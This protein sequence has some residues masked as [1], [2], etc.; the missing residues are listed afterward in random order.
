[1]YKGRVLSFIFL[2][3]TL[4]VKAQDTLIVK[5]HEADSIF[6]TNNYYLL[7][8]LMNVEAQKAQI[9]QAKVY[10][11][12]VFTADLNVYDPENKKAFH[13]GQ[14]GQKSFQLEQLILLGG[15]RKSEIDMAKTN[16]KIAELEFQKLL[17]QLKFRLH[18]DLFSVGQQQFLL[19]KYDNQL[20]LLN[21]L[22]SAYQ[23]QADKGNIPLK[24]V[25]RLKG[26]YLKLNNDRAEL[27]KQYY[28]T[29]ANLQTLLQ[30][31]SLVVFQFSEEEIAKY[32][33]VVPVAE[34][35][36]T[37][38]NN[39]P[40]LLIAEQDKILAQQYLLYQKRLAV[41]DI[42]LFASYDQRGGAFNNQ[43]N[44]GIAIPLPLW[45]RNSGNIKSSQFKLK[46]ADYG[47]QGMQ[48]EILSDLQNSYAFYMQTISEYQKA[49][50]LYNEDF[51]ITVKGMSDNFQKRNISMIEF[52]DFFEAYN[53][54]LTEL[55]R[56]KTQLVISSEQ[57]NLLT[58]KEIY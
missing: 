55:T 11:N 48:N 9:I 49:T 57:L 1:M 14:T 31:T 45:N 12:P 39:R 51:E 52:I 13:A 38:R 10:P 47:L 18:S 6:L 53:E 7:A 21:T 58:G 25:V 3:L 36:E 46:E 50:T 22:L 15:K 56:I 32:I 28:E 27:F 29:Q 41:P 43:I 19:K 16:V 54:V 4:F 34:L 33:K 2:F 37:A 24:E 5:L 35:I 23:I 40:E 8:S 30:T 44:A 42:N 20:V 17:W 26:A